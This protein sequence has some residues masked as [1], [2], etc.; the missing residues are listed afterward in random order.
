MM[1][2]SYE[3]SSSD[4]PKMRLSFSKKT[5]F[6]YDSIDRITNI[7]VSYITDP[8]LII[9]TSRLIM[10]YNQTK[11]YE[12]WS[13]NYNLNEIKIPKTVEI[14]LESAFENS[15]IDKIYF[16]I[17][18]RLSVIGDYAFRN[19]SQ[20]ISFNSTFANLRILGYLAFKDCISLKSLS[21][22]SPNLVVKNNAFE[23]C[24]NLVNI[25]N[26]T[27]IPEK[28]F[29]A[30]TKLSNISFMEGTTFIGVRS[31]E[32]CFS[33]ENISI[34]SSIENISEY[35]FFNCNNLKSITF[36]E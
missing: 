32:N 30:C 21:F 14:I 25:I 35:S 17:G 28:C 27:N 24:T 20:L 36:S 16:E 4:T 18:T 29:Y 15:T 2:D 19:C 26:M 13:Y 9:D 1:V 5:L 34:P 8:N 33:L 22:G 6:S 11:I 7:S 12:S 23:N 31:F 10:N 3:F